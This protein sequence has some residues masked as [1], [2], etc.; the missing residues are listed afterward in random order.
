MNAT[1][2]LSLSECRIELHEE[3]SFK[4]IIG[5]M[6]LN[7]GLGRQHFQGVE[8]ENKIDIDRHRKIRQTHFPMEHVLSK[9]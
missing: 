5:H 6:I 7:A 9:G 1:A 4:S 2:S 3:C 8:T